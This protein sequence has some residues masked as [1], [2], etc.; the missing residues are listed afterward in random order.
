MKNALLLTSFVTVLWGC[1]PSYS[2]EYS[3][4]NNTD[5]NTQIVFFDEDRQ[6]VDR[7]GGVYH[8]RQDTTSTRAIEKDS[9]L[10]L[11]I[12]DSDLSG[13]PALLTFPEDSIFVLFPDEKVIKFY[14]DSS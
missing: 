2:T 12:V 3:V 8:Y 10:M 6:E 5:Q 7:T 1:D 9:N 4:V 11:F 13:S 14:P